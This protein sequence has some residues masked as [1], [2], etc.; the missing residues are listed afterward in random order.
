MKLLKRGKYWHA[1]FTVNGERFRMGLDTTDWREAQRTANEK[2]S[3][4]QRGKLTAS[5]HQFA[6][7]GFIQAADRYTSDREGHLAPRSIT[8]EQERLKPLKSFFGSTALTRISADLIRRYISQRKNSGVSNR[9]INLEVGCVSRILKKGK[10]WHL[11]ADEIRPLPERR[12][13]GRAMTKDEKTRLL[14]IAA[15]R[16]QWQVARLA[17][18]SHS[19]AEKT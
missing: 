12:G 16:P 3:E 9:T 17:A 10:R 5:S 1:D 19:L 14:T 4:A 6:R 2:L 13:I 18:I 7:L 8:T 15:T 11:L